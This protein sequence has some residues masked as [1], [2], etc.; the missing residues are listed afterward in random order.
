MS[1]A[2]TQTAMSFELFNMRFLSQQ[3][4]TLWRAQGH[5]SRTGSRKPDIRCVFQAGLGMDKEP[6]VFVSLPP[7][8]Q[9]RHD[10]CRL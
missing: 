2:T 6:G 8:Y 7:R 9:R 4:G 5:P 10:T 3:G 1:T